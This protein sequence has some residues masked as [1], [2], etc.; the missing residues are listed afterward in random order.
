MLREA[1]NADF[2]RRVVVDSAAVA[3]QAS[4]APGVDRKPLD[5]IGGEVARATSLVRY[6][7]GSRFEPHRHDLGEEFL[8]LQG[9]FEDES[10]RYPEGTYVRN[11]P[12]STHSPSSPEGCEI[13]VKLRQF[14]A[15]DLSRVVID[16]RSTAWRPGLV[17]GLEVLPLHEFAAEHIAL[18]RWAP[19][20]RFHA[21]RHWGGEE[22]LVLEGTFSDELGDYPAGTWLRNPH[23][24]QHAPWSRDGCLIY[25]KTG[26][27]AP[28]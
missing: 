4:P 16:T 23:L 15:R 27:L 24:S 21:H 9:V 11:P 8:V 7:R 18:V 13:F 26:H 6:A 3:W 20:T 22:I 10:G 5:R 12:G 14:D 19:G 2:T 1:I 28:A 25:V 17:P